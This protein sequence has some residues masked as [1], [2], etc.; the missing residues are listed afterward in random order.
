MIAGDAHRAGAAGT[1]AV[2]TQAQVLVDRA[3]D[4]GVVVD[5]A[6]LSDGPAAVD[7]Q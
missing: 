3:V 2:P 1:G 5:P 4:T 6:L 7:G